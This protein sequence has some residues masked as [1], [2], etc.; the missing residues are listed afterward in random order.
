M[1][2]FWRTDEGRLSLLCGIPLDG[3]NHSNRLPLG[4]PPLWGGWEGF[5]DDGV[6]PYLWICP[7][8]KEGVPSHR[9][10]TLFM[11]KERPLQNEEGVPLILVLLLLLTRHCLTTPRLYTTL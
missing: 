6:C 8:F 2:V 9:R 7:S 11:M 1:A 4:T 3:K 10:D 5:P